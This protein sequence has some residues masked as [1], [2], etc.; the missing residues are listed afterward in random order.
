[1]ATKHARMNEHVRCP[2]YPIPVLTCLVCGVLLDT[3]AVPF[4]NAVVILA[5][6][7]AAATTS[8]SRLPPHSAAAA[9]LAAADVPPLSTTAPQPPLPLLRLLLLD[10]LPP[11]NR[12]R[13]EPASEPAFEP[14]SSQPPPISPLSRHRAKV[15]DCTGRR[16]C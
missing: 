9:K 6:A 12:L 10:K 11:P 1:M 15:L 5:S 2:F 13:T 3:R 16:S 4:A 7:L 14:A 8:C